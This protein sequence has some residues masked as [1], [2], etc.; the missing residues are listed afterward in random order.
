MNILI[1]EDEDLYADQLEMLVEKM[2]YTCLG[3]ADN[4]VDA[5]A[6][7]S[8][9]PPDILLMDVHI[10]GDYDG[11]EL[12]QEIRRVYPHIPVVFITSMTDD[13]TF[14]RASRTGRI[15][16]IV[17]PFSDLQLQ[18]AMELALQDAEP[19]TADKGGGTQKWDSGLVSGDHVFVK[20]GNRLEKIHWQDILY[21]EADD[22][23]CYLHLPEKRYIVHMSLKQV[24]DQLD[25][26]VFFQSHRSYLIN[27]S[28]IKTINLDDQVVLFEG[29]EAPISRRNREALLNRLK[30]LM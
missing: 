23:H 10:Q 26:Q 17:K 2:G 12:T 28:R 16:F 3:I 8:K 14:R 21:V 25:A 1:V 18:R 30:Y 5:L 15:Q 4:S 20:M 19:G 29:K 22:K 7:V 13:M 11:I 6:V 24:R 9:N 27:I